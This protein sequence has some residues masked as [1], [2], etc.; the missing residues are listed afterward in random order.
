MPFCLIKTGEVLVKSESLLCFLSEHT[1]I[2][3][4]GASVPTAA[5]PLPYI[6]HSLWIP[7]WLEQLLS[8]H[9]PLSCLSPSQYTR[10]KRTV[11]F[12]NTCQYFQ[13][14]AGGP[15]PW[16]GVIN[17]ICPISASLHV[18][19]GSG[20]GR[21]R[22]LP[23]LKFTW[24]CVQTTRRGWATFKVCE[25]APHPQD[26][27]WDILYTSVYLHSTAFLFFGILVMHISNCFCVILQAGPEYNNC[28][29]LNW[30]I[31]CTPCAYSFP[32]SSVWSSVQ[33]PVIQSIAYTYRHIA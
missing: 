23:F 5:A 30:C 1:L 19:G 32:V 3:F 9:C 31:L 27:Y 26:N 16:R 15:A 17:N 13:S 8:Q 24:T 28:W 22:A 4:A 12:L 20:R 6:S 33:N 11:V 21:G 29:R 14:T 7:V 25:S 2:V 18:A 10:L